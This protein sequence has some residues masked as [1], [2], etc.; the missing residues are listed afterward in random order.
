MGGLRE[1]DAR[2]GGYILKP[3]CCVGQK[4]R[5]QPRVTVGANGRYARGSRGVT[6]S[7]LP[8]GVGPTTALHQSPQ[9]Q[10][11]VSG[12]DHIPLAPHLPYPPR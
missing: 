9:R 7:T 4:W 3:R 1:G 5:E 8:V 2:T 6:Q 12:L 10:A 11:P